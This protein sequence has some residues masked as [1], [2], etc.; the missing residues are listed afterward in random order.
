MRRVTRTWKTK[1]GKTVTRTY[2]YKYKKSR[3]GTVYVNAKGQKN[4]RNIQNYID[5]INNSNMT[6][7]EK[8][9]AINEFMAEVNKRKKNKERFTSNG[10]AGMQ[11]KDARKRMFANAGYD[12]DD[13]DDLADLLDEYGID[14]AEFRDDKNWQGNK[15]TT[16]DGR[17]F[18]L[19]VKYHGDAWLEEHII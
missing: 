3:R 17:K 9:T 7:A 18:V 15:F 4:K 2:T 6:E 14:E 5:N 8:R 1:A 13:E 11:E 19:K 12:I 16:K 10:W